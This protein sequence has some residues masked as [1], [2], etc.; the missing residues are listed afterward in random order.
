MSDSSPPDAIV[1]T[2]DLVQDETRAGYERFRESLSTHGIPVYCVPGNHDAPNIMKKVLSEPPFQVGGKARH[3]NWSLIFLSSFSH[4]DD[5]GRLSP[6]ELNFLEQALRN[7][8]TSHAL[9][10]LHHHPIAMGS[11]WLDGVGLRNADELF[12][13][14]DRF[15]QVRG[16]L[17]GHVHQASD[18]RR[19][20][21]RMMST[22]ST[23]AQFRPNSDDFSLDARP[24]S[25]RWLDLRVNGT[26]DTQ[27][28]W[29]D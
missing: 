20:G 27:V 12:D 2:G 26:I 17:W 11:R 3:G 21:I 6:E 28:I 29:L 7:D 18:R 22:P 8:Q 24:P 9:I 23:C 19:K 10:C 15:P 14:T 25:F 16:I 1:A 5:G 13:I 4:G